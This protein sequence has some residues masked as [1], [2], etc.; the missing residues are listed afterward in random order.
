MKKEHKIMKIAVFHNYM[1]N[2]GGAERVR[3]EGNN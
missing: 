1:D 2:I 3:F